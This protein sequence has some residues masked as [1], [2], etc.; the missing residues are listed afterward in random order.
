MQSGIRLGLALCLLVWHRHSVHIAARNVHKPPFHYS[1][2][3]ISNSC[4]NNMYYSIIYLLIYIFNPINEQVS[5]STARYIYV[6]IFPVSDS[7]APYP[8]HHYG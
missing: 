1:Y 6:N 2:Q 3:K 4:K 5:H 8:L 7:R